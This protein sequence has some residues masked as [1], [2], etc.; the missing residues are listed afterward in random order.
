MKSN[1]P[2]KALT[3][4][5]QSDAHRAALSTLLAKK[6][7][8]MDHP[9][10][11]TWDEAKEKRLDLFSDK[12]RLTKEVFTLAQ[13][14]KNKMFKV[15]ADRMH[16]NDELTNIS[17]RA[18]TRKVNRE[19]E[20]LG[21]DAWD[22]IIPTAEQLRNEANAAK[23]MAAKNKKGRFRRFMERFIKPF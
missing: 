17:N 18:A 13:V 23:F 1:T 9:S 12:V 8:V 5:C 10:L 19:L 6:A 11:Y 3:F 15:L 14:A 7:P 22:L 16:Y 4:V 2:W 21:S 20:V